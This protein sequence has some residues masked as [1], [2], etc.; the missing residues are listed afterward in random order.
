M[1]N[2]DALQQLSQLKST[3]RTHK[4]IAQ[5]VVRTTSKRFGFV[6]LDDG[7]DAF[8]DPEQMLRVLPDDRVEVE[9]VTNKKGQLEARLEKLIHSPLGSF[10]GHYIVKG[11][12]HFVEPDLPLFNRWLFIPPQERKSCQ[13]GDFI[14]CEISRHPYHNEGKAQVRVITRLGRPDEAGIE[15]RYVAAKYQLPNEWDEAAIEQAQAINTLSLDNDS[16]LEDLTHL[17]FITIDAENTRDMDDA[18]YIEATASGWELTTAI[19]DPTRHIAFDSPLEKSA[20]QRAHTVY[21]LGQSL[22]M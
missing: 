2:N 6:K 9:I 10:V 15:N 22:T 12:A 13:P 21:L 14:Q 7:R 5:G 11:A 8:L 4:D 3:L 20:R 18:L 17:P 19:A 16:T 1:L